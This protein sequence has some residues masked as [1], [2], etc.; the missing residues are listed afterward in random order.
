MPGRAAD[1]AADCAD[2]PRL[3]LGVGVRCPR[4]GVAASA[5]A[6]VVARAVPRPRAGGGSPRPR[7]HRPQDGLRARARR[8]G[9]RVGAGRRRP[10]RGG[11]AR[12]GHALIDRAISGTR[13]PSARSR[14]SWASTGQTRS[15]TV[16][17]TPTCTRSRLSSRS[18]TPPD[19]TVWHERALSHRRADVHRGARERGWL[20][21]EHFDNAWVEQ[22][23]YNHDDPDHPFRPY[24]ATYGHSFGVG[25]PALRSARLPTA[26]QSPGWSRPRRRWLTRH[27]LRGGS[28]V[29]R[30]WSTPSTGTAP[31]SRSATSLACLRGDP[32]CR[33]ADPRDR[34]APVGALVPHV[35]G[36]TPRR[37]SSTPPAPGQRARRADARG[38]PGVAGTARRLSLRRRLPGS[39]GAAQPVPDD[40][41]RPA[42][43][44]GAESGTG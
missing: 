14:E 18:A 34:R 27:W 19:D 22:P 44:S 25:P 13:R 24:G 33:G 28:T 2:G 12:R 21:P 3:R 9:R 23:D 17:P 6:R 16:G 20:I 10:R 5:R 36:T 15:P 30:V 31:R 4:G 39:A 38:R 1:L 8:A 32:G 42:A 26:A 43:V 29:A 7:R 37:S 40:G 11:A 35:C 41:G